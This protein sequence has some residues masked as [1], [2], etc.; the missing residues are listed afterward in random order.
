[1]VLG[2]VTLNEAL[3][4]RDY[5]TDVFFDTWLTEEVLSVPSAISLYQ[6]DGG[7]GQPRQRPR[8]ELRVDVQGHVGRRR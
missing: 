6:H 2:V 8:H 5:V 7:Q 1:M 3:C 4:G